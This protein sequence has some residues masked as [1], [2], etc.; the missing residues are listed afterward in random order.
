MKHVVGVIQAR[1][2]SERLPGKVLRPL[3]GKLMILHV[4]EAVRRSAHIDELWLA[5]TG[6]PE[7]FAL[8]NFARNH[9]CL[10]AQ[11]DVD[12]VLSRFVSIAE[13]AKP[14][15]F[16]RIT[17]DC[18]L[19]DPF[20]IDHCIDEYHKRH[21]DWISVGTEGGFPRGLDVEVFS[22]KALL[23]AA[24]ECTDPALR[25]HVTPYLYQNPDLFKI[26]RIEA[27]A[28][29]CHP[30]WRLCIDEIDDFNFLQSVFKR[31]YRGRPFT[32]EALEKALEKEPHLL[33]INAHV[34]QK[35]LVKTEV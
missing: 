4:I 17:G 14:S 18:P 19:V 33:G 35:V 32:I 21:C 20:L 27:F 23:Q 29:Y 6:L 3:S 10:V 11:G 28:P 9:G 15:A 13:V 7:D 24:E 34:K 2:G 30:D 1:M 31:L 26:E 5:T 16:V 12:D 22:A 25:E 8:A